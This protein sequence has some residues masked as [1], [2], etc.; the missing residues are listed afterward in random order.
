[1]GVMISRDRDAAV[2]L[3]VPLGAFAA[4][5]EKVGGNRHRNNTLT[6]QIYNDTM[7]DTMPECGVK[8]GTRDGEDEGTR[9]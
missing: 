2:L 4:S 7:C 9:N 6:S 3:R 1:M 5:R 8:S